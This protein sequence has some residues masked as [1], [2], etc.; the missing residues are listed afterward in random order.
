MRLLPVCDLGNNAVDSRLQWPAN[1]KFLCN[2]VANFK[3]KIPLWPT[4]FFTFPP[5]KTSLF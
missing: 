5:Q 1:L 2:F 4:Q 3:E